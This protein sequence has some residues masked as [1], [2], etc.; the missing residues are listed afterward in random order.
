MAKEK[1]DRG[2]DAAIGKFIKRLNRGIEA[3]EPDIEELLRDGL[4]S[5]R[6]ASIIWAYRGAEKDL[7]IGA[8]YRSIADVPERLAQSL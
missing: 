7:P 2:A 1:I 4:N 5:F 6:S 3:L 8:Q